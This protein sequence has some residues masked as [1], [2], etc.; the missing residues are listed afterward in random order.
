[1]CG[2][3]SYVPDQVR[4][5]SQ[6]RE[7]EGQPGSPTILVREGT[8]FVL[9]VFGFIVV[10]A[11]AFYRNPGLSATSPGCHSQTNG[12]TCVGTIGSPGLL[13]NGLGSPVSAMFANVSPWATTYWVTSIFA[14]IC[15]VVGFY[16]LRSRARGVPGRAWP[17]VTVGVA[18]VVL[19]L[20]GRGWL[21]TD[22]PA[23]L[24]IRGMQALLLISLGLIVLGVIERSW[25]FWLFVVGFLGLSLLA[26]LYN[27]SNLFQRLGMGAAWRAND[28]ALPNLL[29]PGTY[30]L[31]GGAV[32]WAFRHRTDPAPRPGDS[33]ELVR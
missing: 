7:G 24:W 8:W 12:F 10:V 33:S 29:V 9:L 2:K 26:C 27:V 28:Q 32:F 31:V 15:A 18:I 20:A 30:L 3:V 13:G 25:A 16:W 22:L 17:L 1:L 6:D 14:G 5:P 23:N 11:T 21:T 19:L 4:Q